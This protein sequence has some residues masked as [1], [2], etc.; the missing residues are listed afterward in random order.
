MT[1]LGSLFFVAAVVMPSGESFTC[2]PTRVWDGDGPIW[3]AEGPR[4]RLSGIAAREIDGTCRQGQPCPKS[5]ATQARDALVGLIGRPIGVSSGGHI[6]VGGQALR[7]RSDGSA[8]GSRTAAW[9]LSPKSG[10]L[11]CAMV[12]GGWALRWDRYWRGHDCPR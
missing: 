6:L 1:I 9:C 5:S 11:S 12:K 7:C 3:C 10:D 4:I 8:G 2:T